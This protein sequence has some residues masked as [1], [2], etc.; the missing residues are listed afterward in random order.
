MDNGWFMHRND[1]QFTHGRRNV[2]GKIRVIKLADFGVSSYCH[3]KHH[4]DPFRGDVR[5]TGEDHQQKDRDLQS[6]PPKKIEKAFFTIL[7]YRCI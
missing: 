3:V 1:G 2:A 7:V 5:K 4:G 6:N